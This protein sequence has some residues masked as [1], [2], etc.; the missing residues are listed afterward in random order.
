ME[1]ENI[2]GLGEAVLKRVSQ[3]C[4][5]VKGKEVGN[6]SAHGGPE[7]TEGGGRGGDVG[8][9]ERQRPLVEC[10]LTDAGASTTQASHPIFPAAS[11][12]LRSGHRDRVTSFCH[13]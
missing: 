8:W 6:R 5:Y 3:T 10:S 11:S 12:H 4:F 9:S 1:P 7:R 13:V 2:Q